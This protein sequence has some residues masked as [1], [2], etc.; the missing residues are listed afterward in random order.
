MNGDKFSFY[1][2]QWWYYLKRKFNKERRLDDKWKYFNN[3][4][5]RK[6]IILVTEFMFESKYSGKAIVNPSRNTEKYCLRPQSSKKDKYET[7][8]LSY[9]I[10]FEI[11]HY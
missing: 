2:T 4:T 10:N 1:K 9:G 6:G 11:T 5:E 8:S 7:S 3:I